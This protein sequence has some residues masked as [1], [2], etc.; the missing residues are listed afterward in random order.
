MNHF[1][2]FIIV[3]WYYTVMLIYAFAILFIHFAV[4]VTCNSPI[5]TI[6]F[7]HKILLNSWWTYIFFLTM[8]FSTLFI[9]PTFLP[10][11]VLTIVRWLFPHS[12]THSKWSW[13]TLKTAICYR[14]T[15]I[16]IIFLRLYQNSSFSCFLRH[17]PFRNTAIGRC[18]PINLLIDKLNFL[19][20]TAFHDIGFHYVVTI[21]G[22]TDYFLWSQK[23]LRLINLVL[24]LNIAFLLGCR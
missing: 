3:S 1:I 16:R 23:H 10:R 22:F 7:L 4:I 12:L 21:E 24:L 6:L 19:I 13:C 11:L 5:S 18:W 17:F 20:Q 15:S 8:S 2:A 9:L 14:L